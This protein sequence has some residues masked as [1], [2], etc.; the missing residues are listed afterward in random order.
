MNYQERLSRIDFDK[1]G[2]KIKM[3]H[4]WKPCP[5]E[6]DFILLEIVELICEG[7]SKKGICEKHNV[8][9]YTL[10]K[11]LELFYMKHSD[12]VKNLN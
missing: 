3:K 2:K 1:L 5:L 7:M 4:K 11:Y 10:N 12:I 8:S 9:V 6:D